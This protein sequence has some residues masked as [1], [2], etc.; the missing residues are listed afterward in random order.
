MIDG[1]NP[2]IYPM[3]LNSCS[4]SHI[5]PNYIPTIYLKYISTLS[6]EY[7]IPNI[8]ASRR[9]NPGSSSVNSM[10]WRP[11]CASSRPSSW[12]WLPRRQQM[13]RQRMRLRRISRP[14][15]RAG[16]S[17][18]PSRSGSSALDAEMD[19]FEMG[20]IRK[21]SGRW[22]WRFWKIFVWWYGISKK[23][24]TSENR[25]MERIL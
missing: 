16:A 24:G 14:R 6:H 5:D 4:I 9:P 8:S 17:R 2:Q 11:T 13:R 25:K 7:H 21:N 23:D 22:E 3:S 1:F 20:K 12:P 18:R 19:G 10:A 15:W